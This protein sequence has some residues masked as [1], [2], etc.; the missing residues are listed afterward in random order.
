LIEDNKEKLEIS[1]YSL[2]QT[3]LEQIF[4][5]FAQVYDESRN[6][7]LARRASTKGGEGLPGLP[8]PSVLEGYQKEASPDPVN[9][10]TSY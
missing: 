10:E 4:N 2:S 9:N 5:M 8:D 3:T 1:E 6:A 7:Y